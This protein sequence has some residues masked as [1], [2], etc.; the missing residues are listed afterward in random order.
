MIKKRIIELIEYKKVKKEKFF[1]DMGVTSA[2]F[3]GKASE[4]PVNSDI[5]ANIFAIF[6]D[7]NLEWLI[8]GKGEMLKMNTL[9][10]PEDKVS[11]KKYEEKVE[12]CVR[13][14]MELEAVKAA[15]ARYAK[16]EAD[17]SIT[18]SPVLP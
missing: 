13:L 11:L 3:R 5:I 8:T 17:V 12:E 15:A 14:K 6:P 1:S 7:V 18:T 2:N 9:K 10:E 4:T 16:K